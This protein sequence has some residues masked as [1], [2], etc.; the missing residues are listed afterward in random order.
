MDAKKKKRKKKK[1]ENDWIFGISLLQC[2]FD[3]IF[4]S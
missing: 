2:S 4:S 1:E 3:K